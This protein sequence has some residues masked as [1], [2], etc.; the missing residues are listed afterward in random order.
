MLGRRPICR[1]AVISL[2]MV[3]TPI[4]RTAVDWVAQ[5]L[6]ILSPLRG[7]KCAEV[8]EFVKLNGICP[9]IFIPI[10]TSNVSKYIAG[11]IATPCWVALL[12]LL[13]AAPMVARSQTLERPITLG[14]SMVLSG[15]WA[16]WGLPIRNGLE[17]G[18][19]QSKNL[20]TLQFQ[21]DGCEAKRSLTNFNKFLSVDNSK[22]IVLGCMES[23][24]ATLPLAESKGAAVLVMG[25]MSREYLHKFPHLISLYSLV[26]AEAYYLVPYIKERINAQRLAIIH[27]SQTYGEYLGSGVEDL[28]V[29]AGLVV[30]RFPLNLRM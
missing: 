29:K 10:E 22:L 16:S 18:A 25:G 3:W 19:A 26:D 12:T 14:V 30:V 2:H 23:I 4:I 9:H 24:E 20:T 27:H 5:G 6:A 7:Q 28:A 8:A 1:F 13:L 21:D 11:R 17:L 15:P